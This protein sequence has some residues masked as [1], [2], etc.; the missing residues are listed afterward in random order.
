MSNTKET[1]DA[2]FPF[3]DMT[4]NSEPDLFSAGTSQ[5]ITLRD[6]FAGL[7]MQGLVAGSFALGKGYDEDVLAQSAYAMADEMLKARKQ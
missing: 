5:G 4:F 2:A 3:W 1:G 6:H 7:A